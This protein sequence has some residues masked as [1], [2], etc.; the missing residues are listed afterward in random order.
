MHVLYLRVA[1]KHIC[2]W[3]RGNSL[4]DRLCCFVCFGPQQSALHVQF[5]PQSQAIGRPHGRTSQASKSQAARLFVEETFHCRSN[6]KAAVRN[7]DAYV[8][9]IR[10]ERDAWRR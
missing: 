2:I 6:V 8:E 5:V 1:C 3:I 10:G 9:E 4:A 7:D